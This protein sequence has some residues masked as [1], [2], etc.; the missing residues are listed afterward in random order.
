M[1]KGS[2]LTW[3]IGNPPCWKTALFLNITDF[4]KTCWQSPVE[5]DSGSSKC[6]PILVE[7]T[8]FRKDGGDEKFGKGTIWIMSYWE[9]NEHPWSSQFSP[10]M[11]LD[12]FIF[13][14][15]FILKPT[16]RSK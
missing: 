2:Y 16:L 7:I 1:D 15:A 5:Q 10:N 6:Y 14:I 9:R 8:E 11:V 4:S 3:C 13:L 12:Y